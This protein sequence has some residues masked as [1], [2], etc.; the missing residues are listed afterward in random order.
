MPQ[1]NA[2]SMLREGAVVAGKYRV[3]RVLGA[4]GMGV[5]VAAHHMVLDERVALKFLLP[6]ALASP[7][8]VARLVREAR[9]ATRIKSEHVGRVIDVGQLDDGAPFIVMEYLEGA[10]LSAML[11]ERGPLATAQAVDFLLQACEAIAEAHL[12]GVVHRDLKPANL[13][14]VTTPDGS[15]SIKVL[16]FGISKVATADGD[17]KLTKTSAVMGSPVYMSPEQM[18]RSKDVDGRTDIWS[19]GVILFE[20]LTGRIPFDAES[21][22]ELI[23]KIATEPPPL[24]R[25]ILPDA[26]AALEIA[27]AHCLEKD[28]AQR[29]QNVGELAL[30]LQPFGTSHASGSIQTILGMMARP[31]S[32]SGQSLAP[33]ALPSGD[34]RVVTGPKALAKTDLS[35]AGGEKSRSR[36]AAIATAVATVVGLVALGVAGVALTRGSPSTVASAPAGRPAGEPTTTP[37]PS[38]AAPTGPRSES[39]SSPGAPSAVVSAPVPPQRSVVP[40]ARPPARPAT[41]GADSDRLGL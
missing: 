20:L 12:R 24:L 6:E 27:L 2:P 31:E 40:T 38:A 16:D 14:C 26:P 5:V 7:E 37:E 33:G 23:I 34:R 18:R 15:L 28:P 32:L 41:R 29:F 3:E 1:A 39:S 36:R 8:A 17:Q 10:D 21:A 30:A 4:G 19:L 35:W 11:E 22:P 9:A 25:T 13:F